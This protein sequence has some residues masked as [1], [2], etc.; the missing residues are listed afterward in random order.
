MMS[1]ADVMYDEATKLK[2]QGELEASVN[3]LLEIVEANPEH[4][5]S[6]SALG[7][8]LQKL[9][10][11]EEAYSHAKRVTELEPNDP[12]SFT[13]LSVVCQRCGMIQ[14]AEDAMAKANHIQNGGGSGG[15][16]SGG[17]GSC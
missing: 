12:F 9:G 2:E 3:K 8:Y 15:C 5:I 1:N 16:G 7:L 14:E 6:H 10:R 17:C 4:V 11:N 13:Q